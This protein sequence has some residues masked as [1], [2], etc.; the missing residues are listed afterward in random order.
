M[1]KLL[2]ALTLLVSLG[3]K[4][5]LA[6]FEALP[7]TGIDTFY[8]HTMHAGQDMGFDNG[9]LHFP[10]YYDSVFHL[11]SSGFSYSNMTD[12]STSGYTNMYAAKA[13]KGYNNSTKYAVYNPGYGIPR[14]I[15]IANTFERFMP[16]SVYVTN[17]TYA[18]NSMRDGD[19]VAKKFGGSSGND[20]DWFKVTAH[21]YKNG[22]K[23]NDSVDFYLADFRFANN[24]QDYIVNDWRRMSL[25]GLGTGVDSIYFTLSSNDTA[26]GFGMNTPAFFCMD[27]LQ[28]AIPI[29]GVNNTTE[30]IAKVYPNPSTNALFVDMKDAV[31]GIATV[32]DITG[33]MIATQ[34]IMAGKAQFNTANFTNGIYLLK[35][36]TNGKTASMRFNKQ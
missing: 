12:S 34:Q 35:L 29:T 25:T 31:T 30:A 2:L 16:Q 33:K 1:R 14:F 3:T 20:E 28:V 9:L 8:I 22:A 10:Y 27:N 18:Y 6:T 5:Q 11:W 36:E 21:A 4:A 17:G 32:F 26:G 15:H 23:T 19:A 24:A 7:L 13:A